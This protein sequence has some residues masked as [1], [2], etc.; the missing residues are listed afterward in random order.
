MKYDHPWEGRTRYW[1]PAFSLPLLDWVKPFLPF[2]G[3]PDFILYVKVE[4]I[5]Q[6]SH[7]FSAP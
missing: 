2:L 3:L 1:L 6:E 7:Y 4:S 5:I